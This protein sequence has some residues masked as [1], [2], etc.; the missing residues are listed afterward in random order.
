M[1]KF[2]LFYKGGQAPQTQ[3]EQQAVMDAWIDW[4]GDL[5]SA[6][7][8]AGNPFGRGAAI[9]PDGG[10]T[11]QTSGGTGYSIV[12]AASLDQ[13]IMMAQACP[14]LKAGGTVEVY[15]TYDVM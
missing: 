2:V 8:D 14:Q 3:D 4:F 15:E 5:G 1:A 10:V 6:V 9:G 7:I 13:A 12:A 11:E